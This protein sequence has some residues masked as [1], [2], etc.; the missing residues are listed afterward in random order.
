MRIFFIFALTLYSL[1]LYSQENIKIGVGFL[2]SFAKMGLPA[3]NSFVHTG[4][5]PGASLLLTYNNTF[6]NFNTELEVR[7]SLAGHKY[8]IFN[9]FDKKTITANY[10]GHNIGFVA[11]YKSNKI[12]LSSKKKPKFEFFVKPGVWIDYLVLSSFEYDDNPSIHDP[13]IS[14]SINWGAVASLVLVKIK[15]KKQFAYNI[16]LRYH[17]GIKDI[18]KRPSYKWFTRKFEI[19]TFVKLSNNKKK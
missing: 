9:F 4:I 19:I 11:F 7:Y 13:I 17:Y 1:K 5:K 3:E 6:G 8:K 2:G 14:K 12:I 10:T 15:Y 18:S 16:D